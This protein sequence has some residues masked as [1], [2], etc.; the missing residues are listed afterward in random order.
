MAALE[1]FQNDVLSR[2]TQSQSTEDT[3][4]EPNRM[5]RDE[6]MK[7]VD[8]AY[9]LQSRKKGRVPLSSARVKTLTTTNKPSSQS[10]TSTRP[11]DTSY[12]V[13]KIG[14]YLLKNVEIP[15]ALSFLPTIKHEL[16]GAQTTWDVVQRLIDSQPLKDFLPQHI[17]AE[18]MGLAFDEHAGASGGEARGGTAIG[19]NS[20]VRP[21][22]AAATDDRD[23]DDRD[24]DYDE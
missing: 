16:G 10:V 24:H 5:T 12:V 8:G 15:L 14:K 20:T 17:Y 7:V 18:I 9:D 1:A 13:G 11:C 6:W 19:S 4:I 23:H 21:S 22:D 3:P 2:V